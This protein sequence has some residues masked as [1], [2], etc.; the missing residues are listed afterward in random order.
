MEENNETI[1]SIDKFVEILSKL[2]EKGLISKYQMAISTKEY[3]QKNRISISISDVQLN[4]LKLE[5]EKE[6]LDA[7][8]ALGKDTAP[9]SSEDTD[10]FESDLDSELGIDESPSSS[11]SEGGSLDFDLGSEGGESGGNE[12]TELGE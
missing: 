5:E 4:R 1:E 11:E 8:K 6:L 2:N 12:N 9:S 3:I 10:D 7:F